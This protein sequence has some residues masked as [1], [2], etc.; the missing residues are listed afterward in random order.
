MERAVADL[1]R[2][3]LDERRRTRLVTAAAAAAVVSATRAAG[4]VWAADG[5]GES[6]SEVILATYDLAISGFADELGR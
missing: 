6:L 1:L 4:E 5:G 3:D 2:T